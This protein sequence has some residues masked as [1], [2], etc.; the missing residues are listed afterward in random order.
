MNI[1]RVRVFN[2]LGEIL[3]AVGRKKQASFQNLKDRMKARIK[4]WSTRVLSQR[5]RK[6]SLN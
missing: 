1:L 3:R 5:E 2:N 4:G 6:Y